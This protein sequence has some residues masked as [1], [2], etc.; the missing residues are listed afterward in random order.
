MHLTATGWFILIG[1]PLGVWAWF[2]FFRPM[3]PCP[4]CKGRRRIGTSKRY[5]KVECERCGNSGEQM[6]LSARI[7]RGQGRR[8]GK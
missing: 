4:D 6:R 3:G 5:R 1:T 7:V 2:A 8:W